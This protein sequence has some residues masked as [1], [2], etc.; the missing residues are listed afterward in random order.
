MRGEGEEDGRRSSAPDDRRRV[1]RGPRGTAKED[2]LNRLRRV[3]VAGTWG[4]VISLVVARSEVLM[5]RLEVCNSETYAMLSLMSRLEN[6]YR[7]HW[8]A[9]PTDLDRGSRSQ[10][11]LRQRSAHLPLQ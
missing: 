5:I 1:K 9:R 8:E 6:R 4:I 2:K 3:I 7:G 10:A 11:D